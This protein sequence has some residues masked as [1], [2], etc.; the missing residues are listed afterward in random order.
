MLFPSFFNVLLLQQFQSNSDF[1]VSNFRFVHR[2]GSWRMDEMS[3]RVS[4][5]GNSRQ[6]GKCQRNFFLLQ[7]SSELYLFPYHWRWKA[8]LGFAIRGMEFLRV[9]RVDYIT[10]LVCLSLIL[11]YTVTSAGI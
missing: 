1:L 8:R 5:H 3:M 11:A 7:P 2:H 6:I 9:L 10:D 4:P